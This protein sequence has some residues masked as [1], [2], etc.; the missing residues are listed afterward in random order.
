MK[1]HVAVCLERGQN[2]KKKTRKEENMSYVQLLHHP[3]DE[4]SEGVGN[5][6]TDVAQTAICDT[7]GC[8]LVGCRL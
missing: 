6:Q 2:N 4:L 7:V 1:N 8:R 3:S 5:G